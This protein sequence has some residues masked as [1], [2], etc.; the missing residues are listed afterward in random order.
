MFD[1]DGIKLE[2]FLCPRKILGLSPSAIILLL[3]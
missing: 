1:V 2:T 3:L